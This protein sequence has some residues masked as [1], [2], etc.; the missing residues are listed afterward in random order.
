MPE[1]RNV[2]SGPAVHPSRAG[3]VPV[4]LIVA[5]GGWVII[6]GLSSTLSGS[7]CVL[8]DRIYRL[9]RPIPAVQRQFCRIVRR[10][11][12]RERLV[13]HFGHR[14]IV[15]PSELHGFY[16]YY[17]REYDHPIFHFLSDRLQQY[18]RAIDIGANIGIYTVFLAKRCMRIDAFEPEGGVVP[19]LTENLRLNAIDHVRLHEKCVAH[20]TGTVQFASPTAA[21]QGVGQIASDGDP[22]ASITLDDFLANDEPE[23]LFIKMD[24]EGGEWLA[25]QGMSETLRRWNAPLAVL[26]ELHPDQIASLGGT[27]S[28]LRQKLESMGLE[29]FAIDSGDLHPVD[30]AARFWWAMNGR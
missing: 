2:K 18:T 30:D 15:D 24:I 6:P 17:E 1:R 29:V 11:P 28:G 4:R 21:N 22:V 12:H 23:A 20:V 5:V 19:R 25:V 13:S 7:R 9:M 10:L 8:T 27:I 26:M 16:L 14:L 3:F